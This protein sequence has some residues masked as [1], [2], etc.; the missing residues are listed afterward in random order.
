MSMSRREPGAAY[1]G[2]GSA[3]TRLGGLSS[4]S[5]SASSTRLVT[6]RPSRAAR[7]FAAASKAS[8]RF[9]DVRMHTIIHARYDNMVPDSDIDGGVRSPTRFRHVGLLPALSR[10]SRALRHPRAGC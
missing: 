1:L 7:C 5:R 10:V 2:K 6:V 8:G 4:R 3:L 9:I